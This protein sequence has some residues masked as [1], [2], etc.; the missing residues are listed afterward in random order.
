MV[1]DDYG[2]DDADDDDDDDDNAEVEDV[3]DDISPQSSG[4][5]V[6]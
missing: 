1:C 4:F 2:S 5:T 6:E 3:T